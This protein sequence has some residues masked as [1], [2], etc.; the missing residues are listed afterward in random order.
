MDRRATAP[1]GERLHRQVHARAPPGLADAALV[2]LLIAAGRDGAWHQGCRPVSVA[3]PGRR[4][5]GALAVVAP[6]DGHARPAA[7]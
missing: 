5:A 7:P 6:R 1:E 4:E 2:P 3:L